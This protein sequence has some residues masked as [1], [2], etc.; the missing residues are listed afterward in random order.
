MNIDSS[1]AGSHDQPLAEYSVNYL[2]LIGLAFIF[3]ALFAFFLLEVGISQEDLILDIL[4][5]FIPLSL[6]IYRVIVLFINLGLRVRVYKDRLTYTNRGATQTF[7]W[8]NIDKIW[9]FRLKIH[10]ILWVNYIRVKIQDM[11]GEK[12]ILDRTLRKVRKLE[13][14]IQEE[15]TKVK[16]PQAIKT[17]QAGGALTF[18]D[19]TLTNETIT[20]EKTITHKK[21]SIPWRDLVRVQVW[22]GSV[23][24]G[25]RGKRFYQIVASI[26]KIPNYHL[27]ATLFERLSQEHRSELRIEN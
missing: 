7:L 18:G 20:H 21:T 15:I 25:E 23:R 2:R 26:S 24:F 11:S 9:S 4:L 3:L 5:I 14:T 8:N 27:F 22:Q 6:A 13:E 1:A 19:L 12:I 10:S 17:L 16:F